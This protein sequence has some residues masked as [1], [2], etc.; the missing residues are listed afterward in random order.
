MDNSEGSQVIPNIYWARKNQKLCLSNR[1]L[2]IVLGSILG[3]AYIYP[4]GKIC[5]EH[6]FQQEEYLLW[7]YRE[8][9]NLAYPKIAEV[10]RVD[11]RTG[12][13]NSSFRFFLRQFFRPL[14][15]LFYSSSEKIYPRSIDKLM[16]PLLLAT[17]Y[18]D[19]GYLERN[20]YPVISTESFTQIDNLHLSNVFAKCFQLES[21]ITKR[22]R[23]RIKGKSAKQFFEIVG[24][25]IHPQLGYKLP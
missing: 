23:L 4:K 15:K 25:Y 11:K 2:A 13:T 1:Q 16:T 9:R 18:M 17:W 20:K 10:V 24:P 12:M 8:L 22:R 5:F 14:R 19:D 21:Y 7:K 3:D 6:S